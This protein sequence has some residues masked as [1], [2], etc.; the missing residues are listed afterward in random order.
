MPKTA[1]EWV[2]LIIIV[3]L[4]VCILIIALRVQH[5]SLEDAAVKTNSDLGQQLTDKA[6][7]LAKTKIEESAKTNETKRATT[8]AQVQQEVV[9]E[10]TDSDLLEFLDLVTGHPSPGD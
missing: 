3:M 7:E 5:C 6:D 1:A 10:T 8:E 9:D 4:M 2:R